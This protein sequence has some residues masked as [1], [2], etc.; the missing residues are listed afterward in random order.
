M[1]NEIRPSEATHGPIF[2][3]KQFGTDIAITHILLVSNG[4]H[5]K[6]LG[7]Y[8]NLTNHMLIYVDQLNAMSEENKE[9]ALQAYYDRMKE[10]IERTDDNFWQKP[11]ED[12]SLQK[13]A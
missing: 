10:A 9:T 12:G 5:R 2:S 1:N 11:N 3:P 8:Q 6:L 7:V 13:S 4:K